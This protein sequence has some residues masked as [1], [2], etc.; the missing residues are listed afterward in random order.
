MDI[1]DQADRV[2]FM[3]RDRDS[4]FTC[5]FDALLADAGIRTVLCSIRKP[6]MNAIAE[7]WIGGCRRELPYRTLIWNPARLRQ[8]LRQYETHN[9]QHRPHRSPEQRRAPGTATR[10]SQPRPAPRP[11]PRSCQSPDQR[12]SP[13]RITWTRFSARTGGH[14]G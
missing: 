5:A 4:K 13:R 10:T 1:G 2:R 7:R 14:S 3:I 8:I 11:K 9:N 12:I 6:R